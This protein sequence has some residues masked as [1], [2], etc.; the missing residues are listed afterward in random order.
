MCSLEIGFSQEVMITPRLKTD[1]ECQAQVLVR[2]SILNEM[3]RPG[4]KV[5]AGKGQN[6]SQSG[7]NQADGEMGRFQ[8]AGE[9]HIPAGKKS[10]AASRHN[11]VSVHRLK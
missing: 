5:D 1:S 10:E 4:A 3:C 9:V 2:E 8:E 6:G 7:P 11:R